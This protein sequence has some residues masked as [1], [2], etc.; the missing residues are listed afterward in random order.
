M[1]EDNLLYRVYADD[2]SVR[3]YTHLIDYLKRLSFKKPYMNILEIGAGTGGTT[4][5]LL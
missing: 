4:M 1:L 3:C 2:S 5:P